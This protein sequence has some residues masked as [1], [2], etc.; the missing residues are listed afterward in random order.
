MHHCSLS[1]VFTIH[2]CTIYNITSMIGGLARHSVSNTATYFLYAEYTKLY[3]FSLFKYYMKMNIYMNNYFKL[4][5]PST[6]FALKWRVVVQAQPK[7]LPP[8]LTSVLA[9]WVTFHSQGIRGTFKECGVSANHQL[10]PPSVRLSQLRVIRNLMA[11]K[12]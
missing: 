1:F 8:T 11:K 5:W 4:R 12:H 10:A 3:A 9:R 2:Y 7:L 6:R